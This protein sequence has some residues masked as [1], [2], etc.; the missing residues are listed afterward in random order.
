MDKLI[1]YLFVPDLKKMLDHAYE[2][3]LARGKE[4]RSLFI[5]LGY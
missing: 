1:Y 3:G 4:E 2:N 5:R